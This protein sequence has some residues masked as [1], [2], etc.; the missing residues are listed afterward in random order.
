[1]D[2]TGGYRVSNGIILVAGV[3]AT[4]ILFLFTEET[5]GG[6]QSGRIP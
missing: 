3:L 2:L 4:L 1:V 6:E 5:Y